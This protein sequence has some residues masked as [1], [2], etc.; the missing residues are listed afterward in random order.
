MT[1]ILTR[2]K[3]QQALLLSFI[4]KVCHCEGRQARGN[5]TVISARLRRFKQND[6]LQFVHNCSLQSKKK[7]L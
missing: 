4:S 2:S 1:G 3:E 7:A 6:Q 5:D